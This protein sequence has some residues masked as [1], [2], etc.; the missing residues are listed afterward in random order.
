MIVVMQYTCPHS[1]ERC[2]FFK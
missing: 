2:R 1:C